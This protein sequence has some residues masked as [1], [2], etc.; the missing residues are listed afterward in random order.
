VS[1][2]KGWLRVCVDLVK[3]SNRVHWRGFWGDGPGWPRFDRCLTGLTRLIRSLALM[4]VIKN[5]GRHTPCAAPPLVLESAPAAAAIRRLEVLPEQADDTT[6]IHASSWTYPAV[7]RRRRTPWASPSPW[8]PAAALACRRRP[9]SR[10]PMPHVR[11][12]VWSPQSS[13]PFP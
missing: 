6:S 11:I 5:L 8:G 4:T 2:A 13:L 7:S 12:P 3:G 10:S 1:L 9:S